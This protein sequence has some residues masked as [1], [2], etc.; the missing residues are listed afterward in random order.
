MLSY[1]KAPSKVNSHTTRTRQLHLV[2]AAPL[3]S[4][5]GKQLALPG[6]LE[7]FGPQPVFGALAA[8]TRRVILSTAAPLLFLIFNH[9]ALPGVG[10]ATG[11]SLPAL[12]P[13]AG[14]VGRQ[15]CQGRLRTLLCFSD[16]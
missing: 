13:T 12:G 10:V 9:V 1:R 14:P 8:S 11:R 15:R 3:L 2:A 5:K 6:M 16:K 4:L 7:C